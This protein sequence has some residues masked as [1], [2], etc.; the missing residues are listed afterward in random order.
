MENII[1]NDPEFDKFCWDEYCKLKRGAEFLGITGIESFDS[2]KENNVIYLVAE[3]E[4]ITSRKVI[5]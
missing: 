3:F 1:W 5:H 2:F 4:I